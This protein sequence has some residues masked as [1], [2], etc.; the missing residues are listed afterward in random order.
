MELNMQFTNKIIKY[1]VYA[2]IVY[3]LFAYV[4]QKVLPSSDIFIMTGIILSSFIILD[5]LTPSQLENFDIVEGLDDKV[6]L[7]DVVKEMS[8]EEQII[9]D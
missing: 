3:T 7:I 4:P 5:L 2:L 8:Q 9:I 6:E 1:L